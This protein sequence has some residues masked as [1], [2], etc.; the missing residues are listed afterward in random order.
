MPPPEAEKSCSGELLSNS[1]GTAVKTVFLLAHDQGLFQLVLK[2]F[3][4]D[5]RA[6]LICGS[7]IHVMVKSLFTV[8]KVPQG[9]STKT[10]EGTTEQNIKTD[11]GVIDL[12]SRQIRGTAQ[13][14]LGFKTFYAFVKNKKIRSGKLLIS[15][16]SILNYPQC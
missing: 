1:G 9:S 4:W 13:R 7:N 5:L 14:Q 11:E 16:I 6:F 3:C 2:M 12:P 15:I 8:Q 10:N